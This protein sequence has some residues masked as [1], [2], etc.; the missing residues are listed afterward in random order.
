MNNITHRKLRS[1]LTILGIVIGV[2]SV[3]ALVSIGQGSQAQITSR[4]SGLGAD[5]ITISPGFSRAESQGFRFR[6]EPGIDRGTSGSNLTENDARIVRTTPGVLYVNGIVSG[7]GEISFLGQTA[8][9]SIQGVDTSV[10]KLMESTELEAGR[11][12]SSG[13]T[14]VAVIGNSLANDMFDQSITLNRQITIEGQNFRVVG[15]LEATGSFGQQDSVVYIPKEMARQILDS[16]SNQLSSI[17]VKASDSST[18]P[19]LTSEIESRLRIFRHVSEDEQDFTVT[20]AQAMQEQISSVTATLTLF[21][22]GIAS[23]ALLVGGIGISNSMFTSVM[24][25]TRQ[26]GILKALGTT[27]NEV[28]KIFLTESGL[29]GLI[30][31]VLGVFFGIIASG[32]VSE[33]GIR[34]MG[35]GTTITVITPELIIFAIGFSLLVGAVSGLFPARRAAKLQPVEALR[36]E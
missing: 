19:E 26:I 4:L 27:N 16:G 15:I 12:L 3:V 31:G 22:A 11:Y 1:W 13:D 10:W 30:G 9:V 7:R 36:Y 5:V 35:M 32:I 25:R 28:M 17:S 34:M 6:G 33:I 24:E 2:A 21:L 14:N 29:I 18:V 23:I 8:S 20:S